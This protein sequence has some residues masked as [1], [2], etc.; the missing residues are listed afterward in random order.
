MQA[1]AVVEPEL[2]VLVP[3]R[4]LVQVV[5]PGAVLYLPTGHTG[6]WSAPPPGT[7]TPPTTTT[8]VPSTAQSPHHRQVSQLGSAARGISRLGGGTSAAPAGSPARP[9]TAP[10]QAPPLHA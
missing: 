4:Q 5:L 1:D 9:R 2:Y 3:A 6:A 8:R 10:L 7:H